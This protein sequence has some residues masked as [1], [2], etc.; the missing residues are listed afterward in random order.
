MRKFLENFRDK[1]TQQLTSKIVL[2][3]VLEIR[4]QLSLYLAKVPIS[5]KTLSGI[6]CRHKINE[7]VCLIQHFLMWILRKE[8]ISEGI[9]TLNISVLC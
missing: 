7:A 1:Y 3:T 5:S 9:G 4:S 2:I 6:P 8:T